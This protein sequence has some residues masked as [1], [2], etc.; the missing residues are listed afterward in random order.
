[1]RLDELNYDLPP[2]LIAQKP[3]EQRDASRL[4]LLERT[5]GALHDHQFRELPGLLRGDELLV[6]NNA[7]VLPARLFGRRRG[8]QSQPPSRATR[9]E[10]L[11]GNVEVFLLRQ[12]EPNLWEALVRPGRKMR[13]GEVVDFGDRRQLSGE[14]VGRGELGLRRIRFAAL[15]ASVS[16]LIEELGH[17]PLPPYIEREDEAADR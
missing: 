3:L 13:V 6:L 8:T 5:S 15:G 16:Q 10:H 12:V 17:V 11:T 7:R 4:L 14:I 1:M 9:G 2:E